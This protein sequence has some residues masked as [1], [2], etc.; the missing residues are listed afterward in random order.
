MGREA[1]IEVK[2]NNTVEIE[3]NAQELAA[4]EKAESR[5][6]ILNSDDDEDEG[7]SDSPEKADTKEDETDSTPEPKSGEAEE[8][9]SEVST[10]SEGVK[11]PDSYFRAAIHQ[12]WKP[13]QIDS[14][15]KENP[16]LALQTLE[17]IYKSTN[18]ISQEFSRIGR[19]TAVS[20]DT[21][22]QE[23]GLAKT[24]V[25][26]IDLTEMKKVYGDDDP[27]IKVIQALSDQLNQISSKN[28]N[29]NQAQSQP[30]TFQQT[31]HAVASEKDSL[32]QSVDSFFTSE[33]LKPFNEFYGTGKLGAKTRTLEQEER[34]WKLL[35]E[36]DQI[37]N[38]AFKQGMQMDVAEALERAHLIVSDEFKTQ[39]I[40]K[41]IV[42]NLKAKSKSLTLK[43]NNSTP[44]K[45]TLSGEEGLEAKTTQRLAS[46]KW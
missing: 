1:T 29:Q 7:T 26:N 33:D 31:N 8:V 3:L 6:K 34:R 28:Q 16:E 17:N 2:P 43:P 12:G 13:D 46:L 10:P 20:N 14:F 41:S 35:D 15:V 38:G 30:Q 37:R 5:L 25:S 11:V 23:Q 24:D 19:S 9:K 36:A 27:A 22:K 45:T 44:T 39:A 32:A 18:K 40:R 4:V 42:S 21:T